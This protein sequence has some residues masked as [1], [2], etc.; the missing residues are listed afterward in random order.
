MYSQ[1]SQN[2]PAGNPDGLF[3]CY[4]IAL[5]HSTCLLVFLRCRFGTHFFG[6]NGLLAF[7]AI[8]VYAAFAHAPEM[9]VFFVVWLA[10][11]IVQ[12]I[13]TAVVFRRGRMEHSRYGGWPWLALLCPF[14]RREQAAKCCVEPMIC[15]LAGSLLMPLSPAMGGFVLL[16]TLSLLITLGFELQIESARLRAMRDAQIEHQQLAER[17]RRMRDGN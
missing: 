15:L 13:W 17:F 14:V 8:P 11:L 4:L 5:S 2:K 16:G 7:L 3:W 6:L 10:A 9:L 1:Q 12:R